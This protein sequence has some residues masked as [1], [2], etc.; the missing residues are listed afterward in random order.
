MDLEL[1]ATSTR[2]TH[3]E[4][5]NTKQETSSA[6]RC[7]ARIYPSFAACL[8]PSCSQGHQVKRDQSVLSRAYTGEI[9][10]DT[11]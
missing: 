7:S 4:Q 11:L 9:I 6:M 3:A 2:G 1:R 10:V 8:A 5:N